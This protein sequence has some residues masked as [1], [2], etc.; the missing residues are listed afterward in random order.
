MMKEIDIPKKDKGSF[1]EDSF[2]QRRDI[3]GC[4]S[5][6]GHVTS[7]CLQKENSEKLKGAWTHK[8]TKRNRK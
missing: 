4:N 2:S 7:K 3:L 5:P 8:Q 1:R 6:M